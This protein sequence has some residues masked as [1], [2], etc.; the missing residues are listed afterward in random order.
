MTSEC[1]FYDLP[2]KFVE[3]VKRRL[4]RLDTPRAGSIF[5]DTFEDGMRLI[6]SRILQDHKREKEIIEAYT[7]LKKLTFDRSYIV[8]ELRNKHYAN[9]LKN[10]GVSTKPTQEEPE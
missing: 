5:P 10:I 6:Y 2:E 3:E 4:A 1:F 8:Q 9:H 7:R